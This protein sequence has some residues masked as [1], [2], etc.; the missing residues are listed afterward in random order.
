MRPTPRQQPRERGQAA[1]SDEG[2][3]PGSGSPTVSAQGSPRRASTPFCARWLETS[4][5]RR[6]GVPAC[7]EAVPGRGRQYGDSLLAR[8]MAGWISP[9]KLAK[10]ISQDA[11]NH[12][13]EDD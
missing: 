13:P 4:R 9:M 1:R 12:T 10:Q 5:F 7:S 8:M 3:R 2:F 11:A 6:A